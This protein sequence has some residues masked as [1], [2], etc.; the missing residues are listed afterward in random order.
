MTNLSR[1]SFLI[2]V[3]SGRLRLSL[4]L[5]VTA[6][7]APVRFLAAAPLG[8]LSVNG[9]RRLPLARG[10]LFKSRNSFPLTH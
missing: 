1:N 9:V 4:L 6:L 5:L 8:H 2:L 7:M 10:L 3:K